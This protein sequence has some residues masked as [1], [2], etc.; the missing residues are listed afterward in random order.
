M[1]QTPREERPVEEN[2]AEELHPTQQVDQI[3]RAHV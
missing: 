1:G 3:G 2:P